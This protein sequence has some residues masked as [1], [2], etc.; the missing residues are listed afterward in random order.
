VGLANH[1]LLIKKDGD[2][3]PIDDSAAPIRDENGNVMGVVLVFRD[4][5]QRRQAERATA[6]LAAIVKSSDDAIV[7]KNLNGVITSW[8]IGAQRLFGYTA[9]ETIGQSITMLIPP[10]RQ[11]EEPKILERIARG[12]RVE[13]Y[14]TVRRRKDGKLFDVS[15]TISP[16]TDAQG[17]IIGA[18][19][20]ARDI[21]E[22]KR[23]ENELRQYVAELSEADRRKNEFLAMLAHELRNPLAPIRNALNILKL[24]EQDGKAA[25]S[26]TD[27]MDRQLGQLIRLVDDLLDISRISRGK[28][29]LQRQR[30]EL[31]SVIHHAVETSRALAPCMGHEFNMKLPSDPVYVYADPMRLA[32]VLGNLLN[33]ACKFTEKG[34]RISLTVSVDQTESESKMVEIRVSDTGIGIDAAQLPRVFDMFMQADTSLERSTG[35]LGIGLTLV[36]NLVDMHDGTI[37]A[38]SDG[39]GQGSEFIVR[40]PIVA[41]ATAEPAEPIRRKPAAPPRRRILVV[42]DNADSATSLAM[43]LKLAGHE[44]HKV[45]DGLEAVEAAAILK[46]DVALLDIGLPKLNGYEAARRIRQ[47]SWAKDL[48][49]IALTGWGQEEDRQ[50]SRAAGFDAHLVKPVDFA[51]LEVLLADHR[52]TG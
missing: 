26:T 43:L 7:S 31:A 16:I 15:L 52:P 5:T 44:T 48:V 9:E 40:L 29:E 38:H 13:H 49:L 39:L 32:Q 24:S 11:H 28:I 51:A 36:K 4:I 14:E 8:N 21:S 17:K 2:E 45:H 19:K 50:K 42:D 25:V 34:G 30:V 46:P 12:D 47:Q 20:I 10:D 6:H 35:G 23:M 37:Q 27:M 33:N 22:R 1:T 3:A 41:E 18:S